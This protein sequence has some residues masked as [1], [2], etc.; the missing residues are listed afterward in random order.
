MLPFMQSPSLSLIRY[1]LKSSSFPGILLLVCVAASLLLANS[2]AGPH[3]DQ[4][5]ANQIGFSS[6]VLHLRYSVLSWINDGLMAIFFLLVF[7]G[8]RATQLRP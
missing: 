4:L 6:A 5:L 8:M 3:F 1:I 7:S 2:S